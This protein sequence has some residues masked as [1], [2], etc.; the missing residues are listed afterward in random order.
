MYRSHVTNYNPFI[1]LDQD[2]KIVSPTLQLPEAKTEPGLFYLEI[3]SLFPP[4]SRSKD[5]LAL[6][7]LVFAVLHHPK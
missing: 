3:R 1:A 6:I 5:H 2:L 4:P 7:F